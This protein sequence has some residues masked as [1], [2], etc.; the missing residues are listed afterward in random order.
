[1]RKCKVKKKGLKSV[2]KEKERLSKNK[3]ERIKSERDP[4]Y[5]PKFK[6]KK[7]R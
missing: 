4:S 6:T 5:K 2:K 7:R 1:M 3:R